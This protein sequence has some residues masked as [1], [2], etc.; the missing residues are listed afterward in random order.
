MKPWE[1]RNAAA[2][3]AWV[4]RMR[5]PVNHDVRVMA[6]FLIREAERLMGPSTPTQVEAFRRFSAPSAAEVALQRT[7]RHV[8]QRL[9]RQLWGITG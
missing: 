6:D 2:R 8:A 9:Y 1:V 7:H 3:K 4:A 5:A